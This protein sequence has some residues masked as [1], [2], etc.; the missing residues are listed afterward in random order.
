MALSKYF[1]ILALVLGLGCGCSCN[2][3]Q[4][5]AEV[6]KPDAEYASGEQG[7]AFALRM[8]Q[9]ANKQGENLFFSPYSISTALSM[10]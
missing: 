2:K 5:L 9:A 1:L 4:E 3:T 8:F 6:D 7:T 10:V